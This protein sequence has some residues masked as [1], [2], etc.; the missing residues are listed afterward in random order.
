MNFLNTNKENCV[1]FLKGV[2][3]KDRIVL[4]TGNLTDGL[5][6]FKKLPVVF[7]VIELHVKSCVGMS[8]HILMSFNFNSIFSPT[9]RSY[10]I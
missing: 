1:T 2:Y 6:D 7:E 8:R 9:S 3:I 4:F 10:K 5:F